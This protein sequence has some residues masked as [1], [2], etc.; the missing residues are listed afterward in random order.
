MR[1]WLGGHS[2]KLVSAGD[3]AHRLTEAKDMIEDPELREF[4]INPRAAG[5]LLDGGWMR[6]LVFSLSVLFVSVRR[7]RI[8]RGPPR[9]EDSND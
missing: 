6:I 4:V 9:P 2:D 1:E 5:Q 7:R 3:L 8:Q